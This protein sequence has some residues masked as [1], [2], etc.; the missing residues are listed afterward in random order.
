M[1]DVCGGSF[2]TT[3]GLS[4]TPYLPP[5]PFLSQSQ[6]SQTRPPYRNPSAKSHQLGAGGR[7]WG[8]LHKKWSVTW[9]QKALSVQESR[10]RLT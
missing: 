2:K 7:E 8:Q 5:P 6:F 10:G 3:V 9:D 4:H 1:Y